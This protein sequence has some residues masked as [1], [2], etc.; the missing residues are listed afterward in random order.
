MPITH[1]VIT[2][3]LKITGLIRNGK[4][5]SSFKIEKKTSLFNAIF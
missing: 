2:H 3:K 5:F 1:D 4:N